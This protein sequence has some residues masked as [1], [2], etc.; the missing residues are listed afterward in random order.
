M[1]T[2]A[3]K[4]QIQGG[5][6]KKVYEN[7]GSAVMILVQLSQIDK[8]LYHP[9]KE[10]KGTSFLAVL[11]WINGWNRQ[12]EGTQRWP[13]VPL[14]RET[15]GPCPWARGALALVRW[16]SVHVRSDISSDTAPLLGY[17]YSGLRDS[18]PPHSLSCWDL[19][20]EAV[21]CSGV[22]CCLRS[23]DRRKSLGS[24]GSLRSPEARP[25]RRFQPSAVRGAQRA[26]APSAAGRAM[27]AR[28]LRL[29]SAT[30]FEIWISG[31][32][33]E[34]PAAGTSRKCRGF[35]CSVQDA[36]M[37]QT[38]G[39]GERACEAGGHRRPRGRR[40]PGRGAHLPGLIQVDASPPVTQGAGLSSPVV[41]TLPGLQGPGRLCGQ[42]K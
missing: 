18:K 28:R 30:T 12:A 8:W 25:W 35:S 37:T 7:Q 14:G 20:G 29:E 40:G 24:A 41:G 22:Y 16:A 26:P 1:T 21:G 19:V 36:W 5:L 33:T 11:D 42:Q 38:G 10:W 15:P 39:S 3:F 9:V 17:N 27:L 4:W 32:S 6:Q 31:R 2:E 34:P 23:A 13:Q